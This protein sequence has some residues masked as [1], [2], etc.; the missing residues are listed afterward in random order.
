[1]PN[2]KFIEMLGVQW[3]LYMGLQGDQPLSDRAIKIDYF[4]FVIIGKET[5]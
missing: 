1:M 5:S 4:S 2:M 3:L